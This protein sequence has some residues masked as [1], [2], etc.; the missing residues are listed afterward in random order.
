MSQCLQV[1]KPFAIYKGIIQLQ[2][3]EVAEKLDRLQS[4]IGDA[5]VAKP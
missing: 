2:R 3:L 4:G 5:G 1:F